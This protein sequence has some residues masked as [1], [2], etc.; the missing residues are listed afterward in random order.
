M[1]KAC[2]DLST[3]RENGFESQKPY[4]IFKWVMGLG[5]TGDGQLVFCFWIVYIAVSPD[6]VLTLV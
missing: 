5:G 4:I 3:R 2:V 1:G 6:M